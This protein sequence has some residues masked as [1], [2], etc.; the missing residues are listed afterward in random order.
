MGLIFCH[1]SGVMPRQPQLISR[2][3]QSRAEDH[4]RLTV[5]AEIPRN[6]EVS[7]TDSPLQKLAYSLA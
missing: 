2:S 7:S 5:A 6:S 1:C 3:S 4:L